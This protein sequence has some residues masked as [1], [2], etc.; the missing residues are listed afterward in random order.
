MNSREQ[1]I[2]TYRIGLLGAESSGKT[3][4]ANALVGELNFQGIPAVLVPEYLRT[5]CE[6]TG[7]LPT[8]KDQTE[9]LRGQ[10]DSEDSAA[11]ENLS[12]IHI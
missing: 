6:Q 1:R 9:I 4:L 5:W 10:I 7:R 11:R 12:L 8:I 3:T 2:D